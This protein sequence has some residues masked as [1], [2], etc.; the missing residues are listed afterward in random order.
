MVSIVSLIFDNY[1]VWLNMKSLMF[2]MYHIVSKRLYI[3]SIV[4]DF[5]KFLA[6]LT[7]IIKIFI[8][9]FSATTIYQVFNDIHV[10]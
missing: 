5:V 10:C 2:F 6:I 3:Q 4:S 1:I 8:H 9:L 7:D